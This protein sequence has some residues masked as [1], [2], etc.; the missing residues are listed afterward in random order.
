MQ[1]PSSTFHGFTDIRPRRAPSPF[2]RLLWML[3]AVL[4]LSLAAAM[5]G[6]WL[7]VVPAGGHTES[8]ERRT[9]V[10]GQTT[11]SVPE[12]AIRFARDRRDG[13]R[14]QLDL[15]LRWPEL[16]GYT[17]AARDDFNHAGGAKRIL[18]LTFEPRMISRDMSDRLEPVY[19]SLVEPDGAHGPQG[20][21]IHRFKPEAGYMGEVLV[22][23][24]RPPERPFVARCLSGEIAAQSLA[25]CERDLHFGEDLT[26]VYRFPEELLAAWRSLDTAI[27]ARAENF[28]HAAE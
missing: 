11:L 7:G 23:G 28:L 5:G 17:R 18:F 13:A 9:V 8:E 3:A 6:K 22:V 10:I 19:G 21:T 12:N 16:E 26:L 20:L 25:P 15:Y 1:A 24:R 27:L 4:L 14:P 2:L